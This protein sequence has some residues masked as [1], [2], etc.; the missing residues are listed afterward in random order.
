MRW[1]GRSQMSAS[2]SSDRA[3]WLPRLVGTREWISST[4]TA[5]TPASGVLRASGDA[6]EVQ[7]LGVVMR[8]SGGVRSIWRRTSAGVSPV[9]RPTV[10]SRNGSP[11]RSAAARCRDGRP[12]VLVDVDRQ[13]P[14][15]GHVDQPGARRGGHRAAHQPVDAP[16]EGGQRLARAGGR[17]DERVVAGGDGRPCWAGVGAGKL[18]SNQAHGRREQRT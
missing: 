18:D 4:I 5:S 9:R 3:R 12:Q 13:R 17:Q 6:H 2:R 1:G 7:G 15:R 8:M 11:R 10:G 14:Q 16:Q